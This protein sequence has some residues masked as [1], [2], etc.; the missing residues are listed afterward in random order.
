MRSKETILFSLHFQLLLESLALIEAAALY[1]AL[2]IL[3]EVAS[4]LG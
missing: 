3:T 2:V 4:A 1:A